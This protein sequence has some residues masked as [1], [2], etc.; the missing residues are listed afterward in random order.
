LAE[1]GGASP[2]Q[3]CWMRSEAEH[4]PRRSWGEDN[5]L[6]QK[7]AGIERTAHFLPFEPFARDCPH[8]R[9]LGA[10]SLSGNSPRRMPSGAPTL[11]TDAPQNIRPSTML[12]K[13]SPFPLIPFK[14]V[15][16]PRKL[17]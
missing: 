17:K 10:R 5:F 11:V 15:S 3:L 2:V 4:E 9:H 1:P 8:P 6:S 13:P 14:K 7:R 16:S 12:S